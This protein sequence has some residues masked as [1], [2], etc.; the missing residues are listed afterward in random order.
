[1]RYTNQFL[2][3]AALLIGATATAQA[4]EVTSLN[5]EWQYRK[6]TVTPWGVYPDIYIPKADTVVNLPHTFN[7]HDFM[8][9]AG[10]YRGEGT[11]IKELDVP[12]TWRGKRVFVKFEGAA[13]VANILV[14][15]SQ[16][17]VHKGAYNAFA[18]ELTDYLDYGK[19]N[20]L[21]VTCNNAHAFDVAT[22]T[23][24]FNILGGLYRDVWLEVTDDV[25]ISP[26]YYGSDGLLVH[27]NFVNEQR[28]ELSAEV[29]L[30]TKSDYKGCEV[31]F[32]V[33][34]AE[35]NT[36]VSSSS[37][38]IYRDQT[39]I[40]VAIDRPHLWNGTADPYL[41]KRASSSM[42]VRSNSVAFRA[43][44]TGSSMPLPSRRNST[45]PTLTSSR[46]WVSTRFV[47]PTTRRPTICSTNPTAAVCS[48]GKKSHLSATTYPLSSTT[49]CACSSAR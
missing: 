32:T 34:D 38:G 36:V 19:K 21:S 16:I 23:G 44:R 26:L 29:H 28:A 43:I 25:C 8:S 47:S 48:F 6:G 9:D 37:T 11:Y 30:S 13:S 1:M 17:A 2:L 18:V 4:R 10:Y 22:Q 46:R 12:E 35:G 5:A 3:A 15:F 41:Y 45:T 39:L 33:L 24:D 27:Q 7:E 14:N 42:A 31:E 40:N 20:Y 49:T